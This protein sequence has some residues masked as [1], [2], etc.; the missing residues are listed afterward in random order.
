MS[1]LCSQKGGG[2]MYRKCMIIVFITLFAPVACFGF[3]LGLG[4]KLGA[5][6]PFFSGQD[7]KDVL[8]AATI[9]SG[10][11]A[12]GASFS[13][14]FKVGFSGGVY[15]TLGF[16]DFLALQTEAIF[17]MGGGAI[18]FPEN[19]EL[20]S[21]REAY[22]VSMIEVPVLLKLRFGYRKGD[23]VK[24]STYAVSRKAKHPKYIR[25]KK[26]KPSKYIMAGPGMAFL[27]GDGN[28]VVK[29]DGYKEGSWP[30]SDDFFA[31]SYAFLVFGAGFEG[32][33]SDVLDCVELRYHMGL[34]S[35]LD[36][37][38]NLDEYRGNNIQL[39]LG[40]KLGSSRE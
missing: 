26:I 32:F 3:D 31:G 18:G 39:L 19:D 9:A 10:V 14:R 37:S 34:T 2:A 36:E 25:S 6:Y 29:I 27:L 38:N 20:Y 40:F 21:Y 23:N 15:A 13:T 16:F 5:G 4:V 17:S 8:E 11:D 24:P 33:G 35:V 30:L 12:Y 22:N 28:V 1:N 7:Y